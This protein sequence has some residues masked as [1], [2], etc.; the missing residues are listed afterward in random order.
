MSSG[1]LRTSSKRCP[2]L[3][4]VPL[5]KYRPRSEMFKH[6]TFCP[7]IADSQGR[8]LTGIWSATRRALRRSAIGM[9]DSSCC[10]GEPAGG[11]VEDSTIAD[12]CNHFYIFCR[13]T[14][15]SPVLKRTP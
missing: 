15:D 11:E 5:A 13:V 9:E 6:S 14:T 2:G 1:I 7:A 4:F 8:T 12:E 10:V 3:N